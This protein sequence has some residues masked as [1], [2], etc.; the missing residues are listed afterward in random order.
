[1]F[2]AIVKEKVICSKCNADLTFKVGMA[3][4]GKGGFNKCNHCG[5][6]EAYYIFDCMSSADITQNDVDL[7]RKYQQTLAKDWWDNNPTVTQIACFGF[8]C[9]GYGKV[10]RG[11][12]YFVETNIECERCYNKRFSGALDT[13]KRDPNYYGTGLVRR[14]RTM[15]SRQTDIKK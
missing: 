2:N 9:D 14:A 7:I 11:M 3:S 8:D 1:M 4:I 6:N 10:E 5:N 12:G 13:L 15:F